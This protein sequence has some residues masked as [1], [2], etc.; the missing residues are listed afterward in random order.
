M[1][2]LT[3]VIT[4]DVNLSLATGCVPQCFKTAQIRPLLKIK[5]IVWTLKASRTLDQCV[6]FRL[7][8]KSLRKPSVFSLSVILKLTTWM[9]PINRL[10][11]FFIV[12]GPRPCSEFMMIF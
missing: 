9:K 12:R 6:N 1:S 4:E 7:F 5:K 8:L 3:P 11:R 2:V 10:I